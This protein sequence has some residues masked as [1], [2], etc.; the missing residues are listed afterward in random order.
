MESHHGPQE[1]I[2]A[3]NA[4][5]PSSL[6]NYTNHTVPISPL[7]R[8]FSRTEDRGSGLA[9]ELGGYRVGGPDL[10]LRGDR[11]D[12]FGVKGKSAASVVDRQ[13]PLPRGND[14]MSQL[15]RQTLSCALRSYTTEAFSDVVSAT[16][17]LP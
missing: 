5:L 9:I 8:H 17:S 14:Q 11:A 13:V 1:L 10:R 6:C 16:L 3:Q 4:S 15:K 7:Q 12:G 2:S